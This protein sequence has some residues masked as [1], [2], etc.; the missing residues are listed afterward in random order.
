MDLPLHLRMDPL[1]AVHLLGALPVLDSLDFRIVDAVP[2]LRQHPD[3]VNQ[4]G[5]RALLI[6]DDLTLG[7]H[8]RDV[9]RGEAGRP[10]PPADG[11]LEE[12]VRALVYGQAPDLDS[13][14]GFGVLVDVADFDFSDALVSH[15]NSNIAIETGAL[16]DVQKPSNRVIYENNLPILV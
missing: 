13:A 1:V 16:C 11:L 15:S 7:E 9:L 2:A 14:A 12:L 5:L 8:R 10:P 4:V 3:I 6:A